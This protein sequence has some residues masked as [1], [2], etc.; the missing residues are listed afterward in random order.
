MYRE[1]EIHT[2]R[3]GERA[4]RERVTQRER[5]TRESVE[6]CEIES[7]ERQDQREERAGGDN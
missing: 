5:E 2:E 4:Y 3:G 6:R 1:R 7:W